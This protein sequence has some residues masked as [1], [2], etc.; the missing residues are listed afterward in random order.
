MVKA[1]KI[2]KISW[3]ARIMLCGVAAAFCLSV[4]YGHGALTVSAALKPGNYTITA[5]PS[6]RHP[7]TGAIED[8]GQ[9]EGIGQGMTES[10]LDSSALLE[11]DSSGRLFVTVRYHLMQYVTN[12]GFKA[13]SSE[14]WSD[15]SYKT[16]QETED[17]SDFRLE[18][19]SLDTV[20]RGTAYIAPMGRD[21]VYF[22]TVSNPKASSKK[23]IP[24][25]T[26]KSE[27]SL[28]RLAGANN[29]Y[30]DGSADFQTANTEDMQKKDPDI[31]LRA[32]HALPDDVV[33]MFKKEFETN[34]IWKHFRAVQTGRVYDLP[35][36]QFEMSAKFNYP[37]PWKPFRKTCIPRRTINDC[38]V[39]F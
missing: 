8:P 15:V 35:C 11:A 29:V 1:R 27:G 16:V 25:Q 26:E 28:V 5:Q 34:D 23:A 4:A 18:L 6:Y 10:L 17:S 22:F 32:A 2:V 20:V 12:V 24:A 19:P 3:A 38:L 9:N 30:E 14:K 39:S 31:T 36:D 33:E 37:E 13:E 7:V 21:V